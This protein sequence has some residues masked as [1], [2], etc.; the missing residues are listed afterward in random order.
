MKRQAIFVITVCLAVIFS[1]NVIYTA[2][3]A[4]CTILQIGLNETIKRALDTS[5]E[6]QIKDREVDRSLGAY[7]EERSEMLPHFSAQSTW[8]RN[9]S[10]PG[11]A[12]GEVA[13]Y[14]STSGIDA[15]QVLWSFGRVMYAVDSAR[16][17]V[18]AT[19]LNRD[20]S[21][22]EIIYIAKLSY[23][24]TLLA[25]NTLVITEKSYANALD[26]KKL[27]E[28]RS[29]GGRSSR[30]E[31]V[32]MNADVASRV[33]TVNESRTQFDA[34]IETLKKLID[35]GHE[36]DISLT[37]DFRDQYEDY[38][39]NELVG[40]MEKR[41]PYLKSL[42]KNIE[43][44]DSKLKSRNAAL[45]PTVSA[46][47]SLNYAGG[48]ND[49][50]FPDYG[51]L[52]EYSLVGVKVDIPIW[53]GGKKQAQISQSKADKDIASLRKKQAWRN[54]VL[55]LKKAYL[56]FE[57]YKNNLK[58]NIDA[59]DLA[60]ESFKQTQEMFASGQVTLTDLNDA[61]LLMT[62]QRL[63]K[64]MTLFNINI[65]LARIEKLIAE[66]YEKQDIVKKS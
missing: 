25:E 62:N 56:E 42:D 11:S 9:I 40:L 12:A 47:S 3:A 15:S 35:V 49:H 51:D 37:G 41:E 13:D 30:Y 66:N 64:E 19:K 27:L 36:C 7:R 21:R 63:N 26:N 6:L 33:P 60:Q 39:F 34:A 57:Q 28:Q 20:A 31:I 2:R 18:E 44:A 59:V 45:F 14:E 32:R 38:S 65:T 43:S 52:G 46:F 1:L 8:I 22:Q 54:Y 5:E 55:E 10:Y 17:A 48:S 29:Y 61:E 58:A 23:Y 16:K 24:T 53:E 4:E 50:S